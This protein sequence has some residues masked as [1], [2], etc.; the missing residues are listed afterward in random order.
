VIHHA[1]PGSIVVFH[2]SEK[3]FDRLR[4]ALPAVLKHFGDKGYRMEGIPVSAGA[5]QMIPK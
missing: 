5:A 1:R 2:D 3:A 4:T